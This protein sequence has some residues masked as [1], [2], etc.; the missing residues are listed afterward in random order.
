VSG[1]DYAHFPK[2]VRCGHLFQVNG[3]R[4]VCQPDRGELSKHLRRLLVIKS[5]QIFR[6]GGF[7]FRRLEEIDDKLDVYVA[8][9]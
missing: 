8:L 6:Y 2:I 3:R 9:K 7:S 5:I 1:E 4:R